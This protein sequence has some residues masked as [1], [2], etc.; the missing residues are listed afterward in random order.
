MSTDSYASLTITKISNTLTHPLLPRFMR[1][2]APRSVRFIVLVFVCLEKQ[3]EELGLGGAGSCL[4]YTHSTHLLLCEGLEVF[5]GTCVCVCFIIIIVVLFLLILFI[6][7]GCYVLAN[8][9][10]YMFLSSFLLLFFGSFSSSS[11][12]L[13]IQV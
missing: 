7:W 10:S 12:S 5:A 1:V 8:F 4:P 2:T 6:F 11:F 3:Q 9:S 13:F